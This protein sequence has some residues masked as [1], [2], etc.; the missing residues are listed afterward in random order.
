MKKQKQKNSTNM[1]LTLKLSLLVLVLIASAE[2]LTFTS[3]IVIGYVMGGGSNDTVTVLSSVICSIIIGGLLSFLVGNIILRPLSNLIAATKKVAKGDYT[4][5]LDMSWNEKH[6]IRELNELISSFNEMTA[7][8]SANEMFKKDFIANFSHEFKTPLAS[9]CGF[10]RQIHEGDLTPAQQREFSK[11][12][13]DEANYLSVMSSNTLLL[14]NIE[15]KDII[16]DKTSFS[17]DEQLRNSMLM[18]EPIWDEKNIEIDMELDEVTFFWNEQLLAHVWNNLFDNAVKFTPEGGRI[19]VSCR[20]AAGVITIR[21]RDTGCGIPQ[22]SLPHIF[23][24]FYQADVSHSTKGNGL[25]LP[26]CKR[27]TELCG[28]RISV[29][30]SSEGTEFTVTLYEEKDGSADITRRRKNSSKS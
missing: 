19:Y 30:S 13:L 21:I 5:H 2:V 17:L 8:L 18:L 12:I 10:A 27:I 14:T 16:A 1:R 3:T 24:K 9:I 25:G 22:E 29:H 26:L 23:E 11:I 7:E 4:A 28:G 20:S 6:T 15:N